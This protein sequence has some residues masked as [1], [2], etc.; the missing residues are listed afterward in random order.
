M[1]ETNPTSN[2]TSNQKENASMATNTTTAPEA[3]TLTEQ[4]LFQRFLDAPMLV[5]NTASMLVPNSF[6]THESVRDY[7][8]GMLAFDTG[9]IDFE[10]AE[11]ILDNLENDWE[12]EESIWATVEFL[13]RAVLKLRKLGDDLHW[14]KERTRT[15]QPG[16]DA[17]DEVYMEWEDNPRFV[18]PVVDQQEEAA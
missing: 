15:E 9:C 5:K 17:P 3:A 7:F 13:E 4:E 11:A 10:F 14:L 6:E 2:E 8:T 18:L 16:E 1:T 12:P